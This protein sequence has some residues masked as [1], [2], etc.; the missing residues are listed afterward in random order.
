MTGDLQNRRC[1]RPLLIQNYFC[2][3]YWIMDFLLPPINASV[4][5]TPDDEPIAKLISSSKKLF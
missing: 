5:L 1:K 3:E 4:L 2:S